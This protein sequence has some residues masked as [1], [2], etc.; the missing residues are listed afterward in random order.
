M[1]ISADGAADLTQQASWHMSSG[2]G[3]VRPRSREFAHSRAFAV[4]H[5]H[6]QLLTPNMPH[7]TAPSDTPRK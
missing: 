3:R 1:T 2:V 4:K 7:V 5:T 6:L